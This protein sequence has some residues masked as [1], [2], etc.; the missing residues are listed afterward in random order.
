MMTMFYLI[1]KIE[2]KVTYRN[3]ENGVQNCRYEESEKEFK[4]PFKE[5]F[6][7]PNLDTAL[8]LYNTCYLTLLH[9]FIFLYIISFI[10]SEILS[11]SFIH[12]TFSAQDQAWHIVGV[13]Q[14]SIHMD[15]GMNF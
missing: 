6:K 10:V 11:D 12:C 13:E 8:I 14:I 15:E 2:G 4:Q 9:I 5:M 1:C 7:E 3:L